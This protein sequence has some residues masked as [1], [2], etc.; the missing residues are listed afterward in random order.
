MNGGESASQQLLHRG[1]QW[2][3]QVAARLKGQR[4]RI[5]DTMAQIRTASAFQGRDNICQ[6]RTA[7]AHLCGSAR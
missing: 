5:N 1:T 7:L 2:L 6:P 3:V 4:E